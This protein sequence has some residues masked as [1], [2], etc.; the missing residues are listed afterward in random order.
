MDFRSRHRR[1]LSR[2]ERE[3]CFGMASDPR[4]DTFANQYDQEAQRFEATEPPRSKWR[5]CLVGCLAVLAVMIVLGV[6]AGVWVSRNW[7][8]WFADIGSQAINQGIDASD[9]PPQ[10][11][12]EV[13][14]EVE[15]VAK[16]FQERRISMEQA[17]AIVEK[18]MQ[19]PLMPSLVVAAV[20]KRYL[21]RSGLTNDEKAQG[22]KSLE[23]FARGIIDGKIGQEGIDAVMTHVADRKADNSWELREN[24][25]DDDLRAALGE[26]KSRADAAGISEE[27]ESFD[28]SDE[29]KRIVDESLHDKN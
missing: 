12:V 17:A 21:D 13:K 19:S 24:V 1:E 2:T 16:A 15:R 23:R 18:L 7:R 14:A 5:P 22:R 6:V 29:V 4:F 25:S 27:P 11:K 9:L 3:D 26:S 20:D 28:A 10:E 8:G